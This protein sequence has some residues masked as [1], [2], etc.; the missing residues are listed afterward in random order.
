MP[1]LSTT[2]TFHTTIAPTLEYMEMFRNFDFI[3]DPCSHKMFAIKK[4]IDTSSRQDMRSSLLSAYQ[5]YNRT[6][7]HTQKIVLV[8]YRIM[9]V[10]HILLCSCSLV[11]SNNS[12]FQN[13][14]LSLYYIYIA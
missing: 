11:K 8:W 2:C 10:L 13:I 7:K 12:T 9:I 1:V 6:L 14:S 5:N 4:Q 3:H